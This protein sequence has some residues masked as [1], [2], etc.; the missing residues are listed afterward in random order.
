M[1]LLDEFLSLTSAWRDAFPQQRTFDRARRQAL[2]AL[3]CLGR[4]CL[5]RIRWTLGDEQLNWSS[6]YL[7][8][9]R[10]RWNPQ[11]L[12]QPILKDGLSYCRGRLVGVALDDTGVRKTGRCIQQAFYQRDP[13]G[14]PFHLNLILGLRFLQA[15]LLLPLHRAANVGARAIPPLP[16]SA[17][18]SSRRGNGPVSGARFRT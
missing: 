8:H 6:D 1:K 9:S 14:P 4:R 18:A 2:G 17:S 16:L 15:A 11:E 10:S 12:F 7:L 5:S 3:I 13:M